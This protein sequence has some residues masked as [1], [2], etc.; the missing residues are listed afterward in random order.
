M[1]KIYYLYTHTRLDNNE[2]FYVG[3]G[4]TYKDGF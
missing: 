2:V 4:H 1:K 3:V